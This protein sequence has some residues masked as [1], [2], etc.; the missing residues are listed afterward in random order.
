MTSNEK[1]LSW[2]ARLQKD[3]RYKLISAIYQVIVSP[4]FFLL[5]LA[6]AHVWSPWWHILTAASLGLFVW[7]IVDLF[8]YRNAFKDGQT[9][10]AEVFEE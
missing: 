3:P 1:A 4:M 9:P 6:L 10:R 7:A 8:K 2:S 5:G